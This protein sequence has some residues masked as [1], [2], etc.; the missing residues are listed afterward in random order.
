[1][2]ESKTF[3]KYIKYFLLNIIGINSEFLNG[4]GKD[5][6]IATAIKYGTERGFARGT[7]KYKL[8]DWGFSRQMYW[9]EPIPMVYCEKCGWH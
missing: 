6:A 9:G 3:K 8:K 5:E 4:M 2:I 7:T 1:M